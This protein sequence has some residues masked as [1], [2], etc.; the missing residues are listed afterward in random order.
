MFN[1]GEIIFC[2]MRG[3]GVVE[4]IETRTMLNESK[5]YVIIHMKSP[6]LTMMIPTDK[7]DDSGFRIMGD[8]EQAD[9]VISLLS[10]KEIE[11]DYS[12]DIKQ[13]IK[14]NQAKLS[15]GSFIECGEVVRDLMCMEH[16]KSLNNSEKSIL[17]QA[18]RLLIDEFTHIKNVS[19]KEAETLIIECIEA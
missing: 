16:V 2:P 10:D 6:E 4:A 1:I 19:D 9:K 3:S 15:S 13:R 17:M 11:V 14:Q 18:K 7:I 12:M 5:E 8:N